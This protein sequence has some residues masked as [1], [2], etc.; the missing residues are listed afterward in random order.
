MLN[1]DCIRGMEFINKY[2]SDYE[3]LKTLNF[4]DH[5]IKK[6]LATQNYVQ[7]FVDTPDWITCVDKLPK[8]YKWAD[9]TKLY[10]KAQGKH[11]TSETYVFLIIENNLYIKGLL[12]GEVYLHNKNDEI[13][14]R[15]IIDKRICVIN[16]WKSLGSAEVADKL[17]DFTTPFLQSKIHKFWHENGGKTGFIKPIT[18]EVRTI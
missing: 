4:K 12:N 18:R 10:K 1:P 2:I 14:C 7:D 13:V 8:G 17:Y 16:D 3:K 15:K 11:S 5:E 9:G 6:M